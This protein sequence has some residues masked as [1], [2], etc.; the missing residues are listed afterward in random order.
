MTNFSEPIQPLNQTSESDIDLTS[1]QGSA[2]WLDN[3]FSKIIWVFAFSGVIFLVWIAWI[4]FQDAQPAIQTF[5][6]NFL[7]S[8]EW[9]VPEEKFGG[10]PF[11][12]G[13]IVSS[14]LALLFAIPLG[15]AVAITTS[16]NF[17]PLWVRSPIGFMVE[18]IAS[19]PSVIVGL[20]GIF[21]LVPFLKPL[22]E[23]LYNNF[24]WIPLFSTPPFGPSM[25]V[26]GVILAIMI[27]PTIGAISRDVLLAVPPELRSAS[28]ALGATRWET[29]WRTILP[30]ASSGIVGAIILG[31]GRALGETIAVTM[32][33]G[34]SNIISVSLLDPGYTIPAVLANQFPEA[35]QELH[36]GSLMYLALILFVITLGV[37]SLAVLLVQYIQRNQ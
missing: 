27:L 36:I 26:A 15:L 8:T 28:M 30:T 29:I 24:N 20:W 5:G 17:L 7:G 12:Y 33:I 32:V 4:V 13:T 14:I 23:A 2:L 18:L 22:Q 3:L 10:L 34:N 19:I 37:N 11:I 25:L 31:L 9:N 35:F 21:V 16:E 6:L 1:S